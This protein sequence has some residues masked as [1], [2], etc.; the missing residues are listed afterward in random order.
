MAVPG[1]VEH[2]AAEGVAEK[3]RVGLLPENQL[4]YMLGRHCLDL[5]IARW[6]PQSPPALVVICS[7]ADSQPDAVDRI[8]RRVLTGWYIDRVRV[9]PLRVHKNDAFHQGWCAVSRSGILPPD[10]CLQQEWN[11]WSAGTT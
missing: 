6:T 2:S 10:G 8:I 9:G 1:R 7:Y 5:D 4:R 11:E 3:G